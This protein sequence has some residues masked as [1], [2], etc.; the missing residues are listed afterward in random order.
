MYFISFLFLKQ[1]KVFS[2]D[3]MFWEFCYIHAFVVRLELSW[4]SMLPVAKDY[5]TSIFALFRSAPE[6][7]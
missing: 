7:L 1:R 3:V 6:P 4:V 2:M 5:N